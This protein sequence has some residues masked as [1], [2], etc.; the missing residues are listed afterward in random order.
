MFSILLLTFGS[1]IDAQENW[2]RFHGPNGS[3]LASDTDLPAEVTKDDFLWSVDLAGTGSSS[4]VVWGEKL[5]VNSA[6][7]ETGA[8][9]VECFNSKTGE[10]NWSKKFESEV[11]K[12]H[13]RNSFASGTPAVD[14]DHVYLS[15]ANPNQTFVIALDHD[16]EKK[17]QRDFGTWISAHGFGASLMTY[18]D[19]VVF[20]NSQQAK[21]LPEG[22]EPGASTMIALNTQNGADAWKTPLTPTR[23]CYGV[24]GIY[25]DK[26]GKDQLI[27]CNTG[28]GFFSLDPNTGAKNWSTLPFEKR[29]VAST[30]IVDGLIIGSNGSGGGGNYLVAIRP[31]ETGANP[32]KAY[33]LRKANY[34]P[35]PVAVDGK[36]FF[37]TDRGIGS[38]FD[39]QSGGLH[40]TKR[41]TS[42]FSGSPVA[43]KN[44]VYVVDESGSLHVIAADSKYKLLSSV[45]LGED[46]LATPAIAGGRLY[47]RTE[48]RLICVGKKD[49]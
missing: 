39:L 30:L 32:E 27:G 7:P 45:E 49:Q 36:L 34:V 11:H 43:T 35:S 40:W 2:P 37:F 47:L 19:K 16:G 31:D 6:D 42:G 24:P 12:I 21:K 3:G 8:L 10:R 18:Q 14:K 28:D 23:S 22:A 26:T 20:F 41:I 25:T 17:W 29:S 4:P 48:S 46:S 33:Q 38:C 5:F 44:H 13:N 1:V 15:Y 9:T